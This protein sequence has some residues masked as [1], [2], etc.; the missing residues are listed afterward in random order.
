MANWRSTLCSRWLTLVF[1]VLVAVSPLRAAA[2]VLVGPDAECAEAHEVIQD[3]VNDDVGHAGHSG[4]HAHGCGSCHFHAVPGHIDAADLRADAGFRRMI[5]TGQRAD[6]A[7]ASGQFR[8][9]R[10]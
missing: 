1:A 3:L 4:H 10:I 8:P 5:V 7:E 9:P 6:D 2:D